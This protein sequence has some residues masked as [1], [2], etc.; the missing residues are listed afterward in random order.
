MTH[1][2]HA[3]ES[4][5]RADTAPADALGTSAAQAR[6]AVLESLIREDPRRFRV[7]TGDRPTGRLHLGHRDPPLLSVRGA[8]GRSLPGTSGN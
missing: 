7:L 2:P 3:L 8:Q 5:V 6:S 1:M 4:T